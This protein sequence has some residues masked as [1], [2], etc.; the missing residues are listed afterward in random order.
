RPQC[1]AQMPKETPKNHAHTLPQPRPATRVPRGD[2]PEVGG[3]RTKDRSGCYPVPRRGVRRST[4]GMTQL[5]PGPTVPFPPGTPG[6][7]PPSPPPGPPGGPP[8]AG[9][10][11]GRAPW[12]PPPVRRRRRRW[13]WVV[14]LGAVAVVV[15][16]AVV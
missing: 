14:L 5:P 15:G 6:G 16:V 4:G 8:S 2:V 10:F 11:P 13:P 7:P 1:S 12:P 3:V 9:G